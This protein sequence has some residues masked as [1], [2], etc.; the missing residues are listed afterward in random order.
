MDRAN[1]M[2]ALGG[3]MSN[4][5]PKYDV[6]AAEIAVL[7]AIHGE[8]AVFDVT[9]TGTVAR[10]H[11]EEKERLRA[12]YGRAMNRDNKPILDD[13]YPGAAARV[14]EEISELELAPELFSPEVQMKQR[15][16]L[17]AKL[18]AEFKAEMQEE[19]TPKAPAKRGGG[20]KKAEA[21]PAEPTEEVEVAADDEELDE[22][23][24]DDE[25]MN[26]ENV[27]D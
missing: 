19:P 12:N 17:E 13:L 27:M 26:P 4:T 25:E 21:A 3:D 20:R 1:I 23:P 24:A 8:G 2:V 18:R 5:V 7:R 6:T 10:S 9:P 14:H 16:A 22:L 11:R 15:A